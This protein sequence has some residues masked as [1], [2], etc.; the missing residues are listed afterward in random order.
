LS[1]I[2][3]TGTP[4]VG[5]TAFSKRLACKLNAKYVDLN[6]LVIDEGIVV[7]EQ[8]E[9]GSVTVD[10]PA[11]RRRV[12]RFCSE[13]CEEPIILDGHLSHLIAPPKKVKVVFVLRCD[14][15]ILWR[16]LKRRG[17]SRE[18]LKANL[19]AEILDVCLVESLKRFGESKVCEINASQAGMDECV[20]LALSVL[21]RE[22]RSTVGTVDWIAEL[23]ADGD[24]LKFLEWRFE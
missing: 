7:S 8:V 15:R 9:D 16:R 24:L 5:K 23:E 13:S 22:R 21:N 17:Y 10:I 3:V 2:S 19:L 18:K 6:R 20:T 4:G 11:L 12:Q 14:P 1:F